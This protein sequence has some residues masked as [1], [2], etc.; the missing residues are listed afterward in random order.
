MIATGLARLLDDVGPLAG[1]RFGLLAHGA[2]LTADLV[3][4]HLALAKRGCKPAALFGP[5][6]GYYGV[7][8][9]MVASH[10]ERDPWTGAPITSGRNFADPA[11]FDENVG[12]APPEGKTSAELLDEDRTPLR[13]DPFAEREEE[14]IRPQFSLRELLVADNLGKV[15]GVFEPPEDE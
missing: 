9:D 15:H 8:Q 12:L 6:H 11:A 2:S 3:P 5:E 10:H 13:I 14:E 7:E 1:R 4:A